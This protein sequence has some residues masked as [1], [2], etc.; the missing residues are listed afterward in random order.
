MNRRSF[1]K[2]A[3]ALSFVGPGFVSAADSSSARSTAESAHTLRQAEPEGR[4]LFNG[5]VCCYFYNPEIWQPEGLP[6]SARAIHRFI[7]A[8]AGG[9]ADTFVI[10]TFAQV[11]YYPSKHLPTVLDGYRRGDTEFFH[12]RIT[13]SI[14]SDEQ[15]QKT[16]QKMAALFDLYVDLVEAGVDWFRET[17]TYAKAKKMAVWSS[18]RMNDTHPGGDPDHAFDGGPLYRSPEYRFTGKGLPIGGATPP[19]FFGL[20]YALPE[21]RTYLLAVIR[22]QIAYGVEGLELDWLRDPLC[23]PEPALKRNLNAMTDFMREVRSIARRDDSALPVGLRM[24]ENLGYLKSIGLDISRWA[25][26]GLIDFV[27]IG[28]YWQCVWD[29]PIDDLRRRLGEHVAIYGVIEGAP[30]LTRCSAPTLSGNALDNA[31]VQQKGDKIAA[32]SALASERESFRYS[33]ACP[34]MLRGNAAGKLVLGAKGIETFNF[35]VADQVHIPGVYSHY[36]ALQ[37]L[38]ELEALRRKPKQYCFSTLPDG[39]FYAWEQVE[40][41]PF[42]LTAG[43]RRELKLPMCAE[44][45]DTMR[46]KI[47]IIVPDHATPLRLGVSFNECWPSFEPETTRLLLFPSGPFVEHA[48]GRQAL[49]YDLDAN[50]IQDGWN[51]VVVINSNG[52][53]STQILGIEL[54]V[55][56]KTGSAPSTP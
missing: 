53:Q 4:N 35:Y 26:E 25:H 29:S 44:P 18:I 33:A 23:V 2:T 5:D 43:S 50:L 13:G 32:S 15:R 36:N 3:S 21:V 48:S 41:V 1:L 55:Y 40:P 16:L 11:A 51:S 9:G 24:P 54:A 10:N 34:E 56:A 46:F 27:S 30:N 45:D 28:S 12:D 52:S 49:N 8:V 38:G 47:Q 6:Y 14:A 31:R 17:V 20:N 39:G 42:A 19:H 37:N 7:D 22:E